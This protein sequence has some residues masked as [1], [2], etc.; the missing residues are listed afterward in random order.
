MNKKFSILASA[1]TLA[2][3][4]H[5]SFEPGTTFM[6][7]AKE[8]NENF[9]DTLAIDLGTNAV[10]QNGMIG[11]F[12]PVSSFLTFSEH[13]ISVGLLGS[14]KGDVII[15]GTPNA[16]S[17]N[18]SIVSLASSES[19]G[20]ANSYADVRTLV[21]AADDWIDALDSADTD[22]DG[23]VLIP[24]SNID[25]AA[26]IYRSQLFMDNALAT[27][28]DNIYFTIYDHGDDWFEPTWLE[29]NRDES[30]DQKVNNVGCIY[31]TTATGDSSAITEFTN[32][33]LYIDDYDLGA[34]YGW[35]HTRIAIDTVPLPAGIYLFLSGLV[36]LGLIKIRNV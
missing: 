9:Y 36:G 4:A 12:D 22:N 24:S 23:V 11:Y 10:R 14:I 19:D 18:D 29:E 25:A 33:R 16:P 20:L 7:F 27:D 26:S 15:G 34:R 2:G 6:Y 13:I 1:I 5:A 30:C 32:L 31:K 3:S 17:Y 8:T 21:N 35:G 28:M